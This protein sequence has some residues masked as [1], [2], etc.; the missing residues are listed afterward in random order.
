MLPQSWTYPNLH[1]PQTKNLHRCKA[2]HCK[3]CLVWHSR[4]LVLATIRLSGLSCP[5]TALRLP[6]LMAIEPSLERTLCRIESATV[7]CCSMLAFS[8][9]KSKHP[10]LSHRIL[11]ISREKATDILKSLNLV[12]ETP[13]WLSWRAASVFVI[14]SFPETKPKVDRLGSS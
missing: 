12:D 6:L 2:S 14:T 5:P 8:L 9:S 7:T 13:V 4:R 10:L 1:F 11:V 3:H